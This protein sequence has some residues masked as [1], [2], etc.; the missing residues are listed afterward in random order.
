MGAVQADQCW[1][2]NVAISVGNTLVMKLLFS[3][4]VMLAVL[5]LAGCEQNSEQEPKRFSHAIENVNGTADYV[6]VNTKQGEPG[7]QIWRLRVAK[8]FRLK[9]KFIYY[10]A[11]EPS[12]GIPQRG[13]VLNVNNIV[14]PPFSPGPESSVPSNEYIKTVNEQ[15]NSKNYFISSLHINSQH[16]FAISRIFRMRQIKKMCKN[17]KV[18]FLETKV[19]GLTFCSYGNQKVVAIRSNLP[20]NVLG[21]ITCPLDL[22][23]NGLKPSSRCHVSLIYKGW[24]LDTFIP[25]N[26]IMNY[27]EFENNILHQLNARTIRQDVIELEENQ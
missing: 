27:D 24:V 8:Q 15:K 1:G 18:K 6:L 5:F 7:P 23:R 14:L 20:A 10:N 9:T 26:N 2:M 12:D 22:K 11:D 19:S 17:G 4:I 25:T 16:G 21:Y 13:G 3:N